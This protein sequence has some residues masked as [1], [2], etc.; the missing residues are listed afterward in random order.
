VKQ[1]EYG[2]KV[3][4]QNLIKKFR[5][6]VLSLKD[7]YLLKIDYHNNKYHYLTFELSF[8]IIHF[9][10]RNRNIIIK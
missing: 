6:L 1:K 9:Q 2:W 5:K 4:V 7:E 10:L 3:R 8:V